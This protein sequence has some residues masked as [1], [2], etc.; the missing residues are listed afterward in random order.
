MKFDK[1]KAKKLIHV[2]LFCV[3]CVIISR[4]IC[5][6]IFYKKTDS[7]SIKGY[8]QGFNRWDAG[9]Y[10]SI[11]ED[12]YQDEPTNHEGGD[13]ANWAFF[14]LMPMVVRGV[15][16]LL[17]ISHEFVGPAINTSVF[18]LALIIAWYYLEETRNKRVA[19]IFVFLMTMGMY[20]FYFSSTYTESF[21]LLFIVGFFYAMKKEKYILMG[22]S[23][24]SCI[25][26]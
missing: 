16:N 1:T 24:S 18:T 8:L 13:A 4:L 10:K 12:G 5:F 14:P 26:N 2:A 6:G 9:W 7:A 3:I 23:R 19:N 21:Y 20:S 11:I 15:S 22:I 17:N 25:G